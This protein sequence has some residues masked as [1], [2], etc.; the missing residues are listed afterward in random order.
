MGKRR[1]E[2]RLLEIDAQYSKAKIGEESE[3]TNRHISDSSLFIVDG[4]NDGKRGSKRIKKDE[5]VA[6]NVKL[7]K[8]VESDEETPI[9]TLELEKAKKLLK[10][11]LKHRSVPVNSPGNSLLDDVWM[12]ESPLAEIKP[13]R[14]SQNRQHASMLKE[15]SKVFALPKAGISYNPSLDAHQKLL[16]ESAEKESKRLRQLEEIKLKV[17]KE[18]KI[19]R[20]KVKLDD[21]VSDNEDTITISSKKNE[22][23]IAETGKS[24]DVTHSIREP[25]V[26]DDTVL[27]QE[28]E[29]EEKVETSKRSKSKKPV[30]IEEYVSNRY[31]K[32]TLRETPLVPL[33]DELHGSLRLMKPIDVNSVAESL[34]HTYAARSTIHLKKYEKRKPKGN[35]W[36]MVE[37][38]RLTPKQVLERD[39]AI[40]EDALEARNQ[41][42]R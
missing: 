8:Y 12:Q 29:N 35:P 37:F 36:K 22:H 23:A 19:N 11:G 15:A 24:V 32:A 13:S 31:E 17:R 25:Q 26:A 4:Q 5:L 28:G 1:R 16:A 7:Y 3:Q 20:Y 18:S 30:G 6:S 40:A 34:L 21:Q 10:S 38:P 41:R 2:D 39:S 33:S 9:S 42:L 14:S 27:L